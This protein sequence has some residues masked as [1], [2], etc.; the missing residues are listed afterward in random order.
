MNEGLP[1]LLIK[2]NILVMHVVS[3]IGWIVTLPNAY[4][5]RSEN[6]QVTKYA[7]RF[8]TEVFELK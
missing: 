6:M 8:S 1:S 4:T 3:Y 2:K 5:N 7:N